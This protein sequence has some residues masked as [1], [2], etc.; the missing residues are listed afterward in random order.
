ML[1][2]TNLAS[3]LPLVG[4]LYFI[5]WSG[6]ST[7]KSAAF[8]FQLLLLFPLSTALTDIVA[9]S[10]YSLSVTDVDWLHGS[11]E[12][13]LLTASLYVASGFRNVLAGE[14]ERPGP[15]FRY[16]AFVVLGLVVLATAFGPALGF[17]EHSAFLFGLGNL[18]ANPLGTLASAAEPATALSIPTWTAHFSS[19][20]GWLFASG[21][22]N[23]YAEYTSNPKWRYLAYA[24]LP[25][26]ASGVAGATYHF[27]F[28]S[29]DVSFLVAL[30]A[31]LVLIGNTALLVAAVQLS[32][33]NG[34]NV[35]EAIE[36]ATISSTDRTYGERQLAQQRQGR[37]IPY[38][39][40]PAWLVGGGLGSLSLLAAYTMKYATLASR[41]PFDPSEGVLTGWVVCLA[42]PAL[43]IYRFASVAPIFYDER[44]MS[45]AQPQRGQPQRG[46][47]LGARRVLPNNP[48]ESR[49]PNSIRGAALGAPQM[50]EGP[51]AADPRQ[52]PAGARWRAPA[53][54]G[55]E[56]PI[57][58]RE[59]EYAAVMGQPSATKGAGGGATGVREGATSASGDASAPPP[60]PLPIDQER[61][62]RSPGIQN[63]FYEM[64][65]ADFKRP[66]G[67]AP[68]AVPPVPEAPPA[69]TSS[70]G[71]SVQP[72]DAK[73]VDRA[74]QQ[75]TGYATES[76]S[77]VAAAILQGLQARVAPILG[78]VVTLVGVAAALSARKEAEEGRMREETLSRRLAAL[79]AQLD[80]QRNK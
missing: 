29:P 60:A 33:S 24:M 64:A 74:A 76:P 22:V 46:Q 49:R 39:M 4:F 61:L 47:P 23:Q 8:G 14:G 56:S 67:A 5:G 1:A 7:P 35:R 34:W 70:A 27:F 51:L 26:H 52:A 40:Q 69:D 32:R 75:P 16:P 43:V 28:N 37:F 21:L 42:I 25:L 55:A 17:E 41:A 79:E 78:A 38:E 58:G 72:L 10:S 20:A 30:Q 59:D 6:N 12:T 66:F 71:A 65:Q 77:P 9:K 31:G 36:S 54:Y 44:P 15:A 57:A 2:T 62:G 53:G 68:G 63:N 50:P 19:A 18:G 45:N 73:R 80:A 48:T 3:L 13:L 11:S